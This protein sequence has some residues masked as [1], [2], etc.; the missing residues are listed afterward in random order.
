MHSLWP[1]EEGDAIGVWKPINFNELS[2][3]NS[4]LMKHALKNVLPLPNTH[5]YHNIPNFVN[6]ASLPFLSQ[7]FNL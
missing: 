1:L 7:E 2:E 5:F 3:D 4:L 6:T